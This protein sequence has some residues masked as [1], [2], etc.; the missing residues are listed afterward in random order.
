MDVAAEEMDEAEEVTNQDI[1]DQGELED[2]TNDERLAEEVEAV[3]QDT[4]II[5]PDPDPGEE[6]VLRRTTRVSKPVDRLTYSNVVKLNLGTFR[7]QTQH[8]K[9]PRCGLRKEGLLVSQVDN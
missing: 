1:S 9:F 8:L 4:E 5:P 7:S 3:Q 2:S 6:R